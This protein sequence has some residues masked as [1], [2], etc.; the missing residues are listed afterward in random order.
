MLLFVNGRTHPRPPLAWAPPPSQAVK[1]LGGAQVGSNIVTHAFNVASFI[2]VLA[3][4]RAPPALPPPS[5]SLPSI[6]RPFLRRRSRT[7]PPLPRRGPLVALPRPPPP[8]PE[9]GRAWATELGFRAGPWARPICGVYSFSGVYNKGV[10]WQRSTM[11]LQKYTPRFV[12]RGVIGPGGIRKPWR[13][14][15]WG[16][17]YIPA[18]PPL[19]RAVLLDPAFPPALVGTTLEVAPHRTPCTCLQELRPRSCATSLT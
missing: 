15:G 12:L 16:V 13:L 1:T 8:G 11:P 9:R 2:F 14:G 7:P 19:R 5:S 18:A 4:F 10:R 17:L 3:L 6:Q